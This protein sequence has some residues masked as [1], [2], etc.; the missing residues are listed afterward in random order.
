MFTA[1]VTVIVL[2]ISGL[3]YSAVLGYM[4]VNS[5]DI[6]RHTSFGIFSTL[7]ILLAHSMTMF[8]LIGKG[9]AVRE[10][11]IEGGLSQDF[12]RAVS[13]ARRPVFSVAPMAMALTMLTAIFGGGVDMNVV[14]GGFHSL[15]A[16]SALGVNLLALRQEVIAMLSSARI[17]A[18]VDQKLLNQSST[19]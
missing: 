7:L 5:S 11:A 17:V 2:G 16:M 4:T 3:G 1:L 14:P 15:L 8:Y 18:E 13:M 9:K 6:F 19:H 12:Y 10:A